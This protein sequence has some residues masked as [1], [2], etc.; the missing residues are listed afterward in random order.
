MENM[1]PA[2]QSPV[3]DSTVEAKML[4]RSIN[5]KDFFRLIGR[6]WLLFLICVVV[7]LCSALVYLQFT[8][9]TYS[10]I[11]D[12][13]VK[14]SRFSPLNDYSNSVSMSNNDQTSEL[15]NVLYV[16]R[17]LKLARE[18]SERL[19]LD[20]LYY[21]KGTLTDRYLYEDRPFTIRFNDAYN[22]DMRLCIRPTSA[23][24]FLILSLEKNGEIK[25]LPSDVPP[26][27]FGS[28]LK[29]PGVDEEVELTVENK[30]YDFLMSALEE[31]VIVERISIDKAAER[32]QSMI[33]V[34]AQTK[35][36][37]RIKCNANSVGEADDVL[38]A[39]TTAY[40]TRA[41][42]DKMHVVDSSIKF[43]EDRITEASVADSLV[44]SDRV[45]AIDQNYKA[46]YMQYLLRRREDLMLQKTVIEDETRVVEDPMGSTDP[47]SPVAKHVFLWFMVAGLIVPFVLL[48]FVVLFTKKAVV[49]KT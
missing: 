18:V 11:V 8:Q 28:P 6:N 45:L 36:V 24:T 3:L 27:F 5:V 21:K 10:R 43:I 20:V 23:Q 30:N 22:Q 26:Y 47:V 7:A 19:H 17:S 32:C 16:F 33:S 29:L 37:V 46:D 1:Q 41:L 42:Q 49:E 38:R 44:I 34:E 12:L 25:E 15:E 13:E 35:S 2:T 9:P 4:R 48:L 14:T 39:V 31:D 40:N